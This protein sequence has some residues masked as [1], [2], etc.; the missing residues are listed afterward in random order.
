MTTAIY[1]DSCAWNYLF[2]AQVVM[3]DAFPRETFRLCITREIEIELF[4]TRDTGIDGSDKRPLKQFIRESIAQHDIRTTGN[5]G[6]MTLSPDGT[7]SKAQV[8][9]GFGQ[10]PFQPQEDRD[11]YAKPEVRKLL[12]GKKLR[13]TGLSKYQGDASLG[14]RSFR[15]I[16][17]TAEKKGTPGPI[18][19]AKEQ[20]GH[21]LYLEDLEAS[22]QTLKEFVLSF[23]RQWA[24]A[25][26][27]TA[28]T[29]VGS[30]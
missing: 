30:E 29:H 2:E 5:F 12:D 7:P 25:Q 13:P 26:S 14:V 27:M 8:N 24:A 19:L 21:I 20:S 23:H 10:G 17:L 11:W 22:G 3:S 28:P 4:A 6:F 9:V 16:V 15:S 18:R 1:I